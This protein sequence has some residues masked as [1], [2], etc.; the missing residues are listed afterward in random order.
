MKLSK[1]SK[2]FVAGHNG[3]VGSAVVRQLKS[4]GFQNILVQDRAALD[5]T[6]QK[7]VYDFL[8]D[9]KP[10]CVVI[11]AAKVG[12]IH[13]NSTYPAEFAFQNLALEV[14]LVHGSH[15]A[16]VPRL[17]FLGSSCI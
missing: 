9:S 11:A 3:M 5:L 7:A 6:N 14:N 15:L 8:G 13:A 1:E 17:L 12:G 16:D 2:V 10:D 4:Q